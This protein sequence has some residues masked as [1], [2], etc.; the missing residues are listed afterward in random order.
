MSVKLFLAMSEVNAP[1]CCISRLINRVCHLTSRSVH[2]PVV[3]SR[4]VSARNFYPWRTQ[5]TCPLFPVNKENRW[6][7]ELITTSLHVSEKSKSREQRERERRRR[8]RGK[9]NKREGRKRE[10]KRDR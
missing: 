4:V 9:I 6:G 7:G 8:E 3:Q 10:K 5:M 1:L 2:V